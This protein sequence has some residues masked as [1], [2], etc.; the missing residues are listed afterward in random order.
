MHKAL[1][2]FGYSFFALAF[3][4]VLIVGYGALFGY[5]DTDERASRLLMCMTA[6]VILLGIGTTFLKVA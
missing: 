5:Q 3:V 2:S 1:V 4:P 6:F